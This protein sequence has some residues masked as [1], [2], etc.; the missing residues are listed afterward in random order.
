MT[1]D[2]IP[3]KAQHLYPYKPPKYKESF[4]RKHPL[5]SDVNTFCSHIACVSMCVMY[6]CVHAHVCMCSFR[7]TQ[8][9]VSGRSVPARELFSVA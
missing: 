1:L 8:L 3:G 4:C 7:H 6:P 2:R 5:L 9:H